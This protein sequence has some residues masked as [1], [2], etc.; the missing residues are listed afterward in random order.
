MTTGLALPRNHFQ[1]RQVNLLQVATER[2]DHC[3]RAGRPFEAGV[4]IAQIIAVSVGNLALEGVQR[5]LRFGR[6]GIQTL[7][8]EVQPVD[9]RIGRKTVLPVQFAIDG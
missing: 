8:G 2:A 7:P 9:I 3:K 1:L 5:H 6:H 4:E